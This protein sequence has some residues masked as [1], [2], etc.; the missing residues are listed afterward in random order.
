MIHYTIRVGVEGAALPGVALAPCRPNPVAGQVRF[1]F[2]LPAPARA[3]LIVTDLAGRRIVT[4]I[5]RAFAV[6]R[7]AMAWDGCDACG[8]AVAG[9]V[10]VYRL[11]VDGRIRAAR[12]LIV[13]R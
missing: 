12:K 6:G 3:A 10:Y 11:V 5:D 4:V 9:G 13:V 1:E 8:R 2:S 7:Q